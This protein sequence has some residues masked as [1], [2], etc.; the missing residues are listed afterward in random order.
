[1]DR[2]TLITILGLT[3]TLFLVNTYFE[4]D[5]QQQM[6][7]WSQQQKAVKQ[8]KQQKL[9]EE[10][11]NRTAKEH[12]LPLV[13]LYSD[14]KGEEPVGSGILN[15][16]AVLTLAWNDSLPSSLH[17]KIDGRLVE[18]TTGSSAKKGQPVVFS[19][20]G[21]AQIRTSALP[22][23]GMYELQL[24][25][26]PKP[27]IT[28]GEYTDG[29]FVLPYVELA[30]LKKELTGSDI[31]IPTQ[32][33]AIAL[34][35]TAEG[36][37]PVAWYD[38]ESFS[39]IPLDRVASLQGSI[40]YEKINGNI[41]STTQKE[42]KF[43]VLENQ[44][45]QLVFSNF[46]GAL[47]EINLPFESKTDR[48]SPVKPI[49]VDREMVEYYPQNAY[50][51][52]HPYTTAN[53]D[54]H[55][56]GTLGGYYP[57]IRRDVI[58]SRD[59]KSIRISPK[60]YALNVV[61]SEFSE[62]AEL[63]YEVKEFTNDKIVFEA[64]QPHRRITKTYTLSDAPYTLNL[65]VQIEGDA[66]N[67][68]LSS[69]VPEVEW[70]S[71]APA[72]SLK[73]RTTRKGKVDIEE[74]SLPGESQTV[75]SLF[76]DWLSNSN[77]F[78]GL[79]LDPLSQINEGYRLQQ[80]SG[81]TVPSRLV[82]VDEEYEL[83]NPDKMPGYM[84]QLPLSKRGGSMQFR[85]FAGPYSSHILNEVDEIYSNPATGYTPDYISTQTFHGWFSFISEPFAKFLFILMNF[86]Y[87]FTHSW[88]F[89][90]ILLTI[91]L[92]IMMYP[93]NQ[94]STKSMVK[95][96][97]IAPKVTKIQE[98]Y[99]KDPKKMQLEV[100]NLYRESGAN[101]LSGCFPLLIQMPFLIGMFGLLRS[102]F[103]LRGASFIPGWIDDLAAPDVLFSWKYPI[104]FI[105]N[106]FHLLP[107]LLGGVM[108]VQQQFMS[109]L[110]K[111]PS[112]WTDQQRQQRSM[113]TIMAVVFAVLF[114][115]FPSGLNIYW[116][117][118]MLLGILQQWWTTKRI[119]EGAKAAPAKK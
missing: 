79:I 109:S 118:S 65:D 97:E 36:Y 34:F 93:L 99:K 40:E 107:L 73:L 48:E 52:L 115:S 43:F 94:W 62:V 33:N 57:L 102:T 15:N 75:T 100:M 77:G 113:G 16:G 101:P 10:I 11:A 85:I 111:D 68:W 104:F 30:S 69:G 19:P 67:L 14:A 59:R 63:V 27:S 47:T 41:A 66:R 60:Y 78:F 49:H 86:F 7:E 76:P 95:M 91:A 105:G 6:Q 56:S 108:L 58:Q 70:I 96:Q 42:E 71:G 116:L 55:E 90:I 50:F 32:S 28:L 87:S 103:E 18:V 114:Y 88:G 72:P 8:E 3:L 12:Q 74:L 64:R 24:V 5:R 89:S 46:G 37:K 17:A 92:R 22:H 81:T 38:A 35:K 110:P 112:Q 106:E 84:T 54:Y 9:E 29:Q 23:F 2:R 45:Q 83:F 44:F 51:P 26:L 25:S 117:F 119:K 98:K 13:T 53:G 80:V 61:S 82:V 20:A 1:M 39:L 31:T 4:R 21:K